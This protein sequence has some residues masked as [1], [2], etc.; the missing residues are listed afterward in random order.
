M[1]TPRI[2]LYM[3]GIAGIAGIAAL[4]LF[5]SCSAIEPDVRQLQTAAPLPTTT[6]TG[7]GVQFTRDILPILSRPKG[8]KSCH[9]A[10][11]ALPE[12]FAQSGFDT[13]NLGTIRK[14]GVATRGTVIIA[15]NPNGS[16][17]VQKVE[18]TF[19]RGARMPRN[20]PPLSVEEIALIRTW[21]AEGAQGKDTE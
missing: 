17:L 15:G 13:T 11:S 5:T 6:S 14:G 1:M 10:G 2:G 18:G 3:R 21:I 12:G 8:C 19:P 4:A 16:A 7:G 20:Q 9:D